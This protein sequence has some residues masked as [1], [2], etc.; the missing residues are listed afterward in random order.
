MAA[1]GLG[2]GAGIVSRALHLGGGTTVPGLVGRK[3][4][5]ALTVQ[6]ARRLRNGAVLVS[7]TNGKTTT[8]RLLAAILTAAGHSVVHNRAGANLV[9]GVTTA[10]LSESG[11]MGLFEV[12]EATLPAA[13]DEIE[14]RLVVCLN[15]FRDQLDRYG[16]LDHLSRIWASALGHLPPS[17]TVVLNAD[18]P[19]IASLGSGLTCRVV[20]YG[21][22]APEQALTD[23]QHAADSLYCINCGNL[24]KF[25]R[26]YYGHIGEY[27]CVSCGWS[28]PQPDYVANDLQLRS[29]APSQLSVGTTTLTTSLPG[30]YNIYNVLAAFAAACAL[31]IDPVTSTEAISTFTGAFGRTEVVESGNKRL[32]LLLA[33]NPV[34]YNEVLRT[35][36]LEPEPLDLYLALNDRIADGQDVSWI[37]DVDFEL[38][39]GRCR[40]VSIT[41]T[42]AA[43]LAMRLKYAGLPPKLLRVFRSAAEAV[44]ST[45]QAVPDGATAYA[46]P[47]YTALLELRSA[48]TE[49]GLVKPFWED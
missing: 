42:R 3:V 48:L 39:A 5:P 10:L 45:L 6:L 16:E 13:V 43:E 29:A 20:Y 19:R 40:T 26:V 4:D 23:V 32:M 7:G 31:K 47:T 33:K 41:G 21:L 36:L 25:D 44:Q 2:R 8:T 46:I 17:S 35:I 30:L 11:D 34:G 49:L 27:R 12:D 38:L 22:D 14:P 37:W 18:D 9:T 28:R 15:L 1:V 24:L